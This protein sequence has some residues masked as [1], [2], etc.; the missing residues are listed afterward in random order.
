MSL[1]KTMIK[2]QSGPSSLR[3]AEEFMDVS[4]VA[5]K[6]QKRMDFASASSAKI[7]GVLMRW[8]ASTVC[9]RKS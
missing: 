5:D 6:S 2:G 4:E 8:H 7:N 1:L 9:I 3:T